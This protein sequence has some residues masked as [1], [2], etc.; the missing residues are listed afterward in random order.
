MKRSFILFL[1][2]CI[3]IPLHAQVLDSGKNVPFSQD[4]GKEVLLDGEW[5]FHFMAGDAELT[6]WA[7][8]ALDDSEWDR[9]NV[10][11]CWDAMGYAE[12][13]YVNPRRATG[14]YRQDFRV[15]GKWLRNGHV[16]L[17]FDGVLKGY[18]VW[19]NGQYAGKWESAF[20]SCQFDVTDYVTSGRNLLAVKVYTEYKGADFDSNDDWGQAGINRSVTVFPVTDFHVSDIC[21]STSDVSEGSATLHYDVK[22]GSFSSGRNA[23]KLRLSVRGPDGHKVFTKRLKVNM[24]DDHVRGEVNLS[25]PLLW[26]AET[27][28]L[29]SFVCSTGRRD[30][31]T[32]R[33][34]VREVKVDGSVLEINGRPVKLRGVNL[35]DT[36][37]LNGKFVP[38]ELLMKDLTMMKQ[39][40]INF[41]RTCHYPKSPEFYDLCDELGFYV[42]DEVP[43]GFGDSHLYDESYRDI[44]FT[45]AEATVSRDKN[46]PCI[47]VWSV[48]NE[49]PLTPIAE[50]TGRYVKAADPTRPICYPMVHDYFL[51]LDY[52]IPDFVDIYAPHYP[53]VQTLLHYAETANRPVIA[54]EYCHSLGQSLEQQDELWEIMQANPNIAGGAIWEWCDQGMPDRD[55]VFPGKF[56][57]SEKLWLRDSTC[58]S[59]EGNSGTDGIVYAD[60]TPLSNYYEVRH[61][62]AQARLLTDTVRVSKGMN[63]VS[64]SFENRYDFMDLGDRLRFEWRLKDGYRQVSSGDFSLRCAP[65]EVA[66]VGLGMEIPSDPSMSSYA[67]EVSVLSSEWGEIGYYS[68]PV[69]SVDGRS[70]GGL[71]SLGDLP[72][73]ESSES[74]PDYFLRI[75][76]KKGLAEQI[77]AKNAPVHYLVRP[78][79]TDGHIMFINDEFSARGDVSFSPLE[80][81]AF[82]ANA[83]V[84]PL[85]E[86]R[87]LLEGGLGFLMPPGVEYVQWLGEGPYATYPGKMQA[88]WYGVH[89]LK[90]G[91]LYFEGNRMG[92]DAVLATDFSGNG[93]LFLTGGHPVDIEYTDSGVVISVNDKVAGMCGKLRPTSFPVY[94]TQDDMISLSFKMVPVKA[95]AWPAVLDE[96]FADPS[97]IK[98]SSPFLTQY[99][100]YSLK[101]Q[102]IIGDC[103]PEL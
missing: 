17:R 2:V 98:A 16:F 61:N 9:V 74:I 36:D 60:R 58:I 24:G 11:G 19:V 101:L 42:M 97:E 14:Y 10:P 70:S 96:V 47:I 79:E 66:T 49:N 25:K 4:R 65:G 37:P 31:Q 92:V 72:S 20:N 52:N 89:A 27:P 44:L 91:D 81:G 51:S 78:I 87:L 22:V 93:W 29:Y 7:D 35:H 64:L 68:I 30:R 40:N 12:P 80:G 53:P 71:L 46:H 41:I 1:F 50:D 13:K 3:F 62:Y 77:R 28:D 54:T 56:Q 88:N 95:G 48:G 84:A 8:P 86:G 90:V 39:A 82:N 38:R 103:I 26:S 99:D 69:F 18:E 59:M 55:A 67:L 21:L 6:D 63:E 32:V 15:P 83:S 76:R 5:R 102:D 94:S 33:F 34:G 23:G 43:F 73:V 45:R 100:T 85:T 57:P 75:G